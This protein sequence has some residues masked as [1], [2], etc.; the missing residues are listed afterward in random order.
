[1]AEARVPDR[2]YLDVLKHQLAKITPWGVG[3]IYA[4]PFSPQRSCAENAT[5]R[6][7]RCGLHFRKDF[8]RHLPS[9]ISGNKLSLPPK[10]CKPQK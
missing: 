9:Y 7:Q 2:V 5:G 3:G 8:F 6:R 1:M 4:L 10:L